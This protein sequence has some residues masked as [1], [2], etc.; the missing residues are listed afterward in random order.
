MSAALVPGTKSVRAL[1]MYNDSFVIIFEDGTDPYWAASRV[2]EQLATIAD[3]MPP[4]VS[5]QLGPDASG[6]GWIYQP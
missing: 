3:T 1:S 4:G 5:P 2:L 6:V